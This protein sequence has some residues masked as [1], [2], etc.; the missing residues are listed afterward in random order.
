MISDTRVWHDVEA[1]IPVTVNEPFAQRLDAVRNIIASLG[2]QCPGIR[3]RIIPQ[4]HLEN[5]TD[6]DAY[7]AISSGLIDVQR[8]WT[9]YLED[10][11]E[12]SSGFGEEA[13]KR[14]IEFGQKYDVISMFTPNYDAFIKLEKGD[15]FYE[16]TTRVFTYAQC[17]VMRNQVAQ[18]WGR[19]LLDWYGHEPPGFKGTPD[20]A[21]GRCCYKNGWKIVSTLP[22]LAQHLKFPSTFGHGACPTSW[23]Y[24]YQPN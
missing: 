22:C 3:I 7:F 24:G 15:S 13:E 20:V 14:I 17:L 9:L 8:G 2:E 11:I 1:V 16:R 4:Y 21:L 12:L 23:T 10:D 19:Q 18:A 5:H 6:K